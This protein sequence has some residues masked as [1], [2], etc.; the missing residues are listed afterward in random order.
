MKKQIRK[1]GLALREAKHALEQIIFFNTFM[2]VVVFT[3]FCLLGVRL[4][5]LELWYGLIPVPF[6]IFFHLKGNLKDLNFRTIEEKV[7][8]LDEELR[9]VADNWRKSNEVVEA[10]NE[11]VLRK[12]KAIRTSYFIDFGKVFRQLIVLVV[13]SFILIGSSAYNVKFLNIKDVVKELKDFKP[14]KH[15]IVDEELLAFD[16]GQDLSDILGEKEVLE[17]GNQQLNLEINPGK[18][19]V[20]ISKI[21]EV[22]PKSFRSKPPSS[23]I[24]SSEQSFGD[25]IPSQYQRIVKNYFR[26]ITK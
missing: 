25:S 15:Y 21:N 6:Y 18:T 4:L 1:I 11:E 17:L 24:A 8:V 23:I 12:M 7:P 3:A 13:V 16:E 19:D 20:D 14:A 26:G 22:S 9:T 2:D 5:S 10:L